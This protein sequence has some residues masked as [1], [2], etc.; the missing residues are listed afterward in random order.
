MQV[1]TKQLSDTSVELGIVADAAELDDI[2]TE[3]LQHLRHHVKMAGFREGQAPLALVE[4]NTDPNTLQAEF[5]D[6][7]VNQLYIKAATE[8]KLR[9]VGQ[10]QISLKKFVPFTSLELTA[11]VEIIGDISL[12]DYKKFRLAK[13]VAKVAAA[14]VNEV[15]D[16]LANRTADKKTVERAAKTGDEVLID[17]AGTDVKKKEAVNGATGTDYPLQLGS[18][19]FIPGFEDNLIGVKPGETKTFTVT[20]PKDYG[21]AALQNRAVSFEV[22]VKEVKE[23]AKPKLDDAFAATVGPFKTLAELKADIKKQLEQEKQQQAE[24]D[25]NND[26]ISQ[27]AAKTK[28][29]IPE[30]VINEELEAMDR[31]E[32]QNLMYRGQTWEE[33]LQQEGISEEEHHERNKPLAEERVRAGLMLAEIADQEGLKVTSDEIDV[34]LQFLKGQYSDPQM[35]AELDKAENRNSIAS[36]LLTEKT[37][38]KLTEYATK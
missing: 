19:S 9:P 11:T 14:D 4:K 18:N 8:A 38:V 25:Y 6:N 10:P 12:P 34:R 26:L 22:K 17:F 1:H 24:R 16:N 13:P 31:D 3:T 36:R 7:A 21:V 15:L 5:L 37:I 20:F 23:L 27:L 35:L 33:H 2:K 30:G 32:R 28:V 29:A